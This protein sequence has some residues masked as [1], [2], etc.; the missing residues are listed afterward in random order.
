MQEEV[1]S[2][3]KYETW[4]LVKLSEGK[5]VISCKWIFKIKEGIPGVENARYKARFVVRGFDQ[6]E[7][8]EFNEVFSL[9]VRH[10]LIR[11]LLASYDLEL[12]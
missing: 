3:L 5:R 6:H 1:K 8:I 10:S 7:G 12:E 4:E 9:V 2:F 11:V